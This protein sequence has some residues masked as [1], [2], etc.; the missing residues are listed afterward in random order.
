LRRQLLPPI[1]AQRDREHL[2]HRCQ[3]H[4]LDSVWQV[5]V[6][7]DDGSS[8]AL[9]IPAAVRELVARR[10]QSGFA[11]TVPVVSGV[12]ATLFDESSTAQP[13]SDA[14]ARYWRCDLQVHTPRDQRWPGDDPRGQDER[15]A[16]ARTYLAAAQTRGVEVV[17][18]TEHHD[19]S[20][21]DELR[22]AA[23][24]L[25][26]HVLPG[27]ELETSEG[28]HV[29]C[30]F[31]PARPVLEL[32]D[33][34]ASLGLDRNRRA[35]SKATEIRSDRPLADVL[36]LVQDRYEGICIAAHVTSRKGILD[37][38]PGGARADAWKQPDL[39]AAQIPCALAEVGNAGVRSMLANE[40]P[41][42]RRERRLAY[43]L[44]SDSRS[45]DEIGSAS[46]WIKMHHP[47]VAGLRQ[48]FLDPDSRIAF[49]DPMAA[50]VDAQLLEVAWEG[51]YLGDERVAFNTELTCLIGGKGTG[52]STVIESIRWAFGLEPR[53]DSDI[54][55][56]VQSL[57]KSVLPGGTK[58]TVRFRTPRPTPKTF[59]VERTEPHGPI[60]RDSAGT[61]LPELEP[62]DLLHPRVY[63]QKEIFDVAQ[64]MPARLALVD[65]YAAEELRG[66]NERE[67]DL[68][69]GL[70]RNAQAVLQAQDEVD[71]AQA[72]LAELPALQ[73]WR[74]RF[75]Q[76]GF[77]ERLR[78]RRMLDREALLLR[79]AAEVL[80]ERQRS[81]GDLADQ[82]PQAPDLS[83]GRD[84]G[85]LPNQDLISRAASAVTAAVGEMDR[86]L[87]EAGAAV[88]A[89]RE[90]LGETQ[91]TWE[92]R[93]AA[94]QADFDRALREL[95][96]SAPDAD[97]EQYLDV[98]RRIEQLEPLRSA[99]P[100][101]EARVD[102][103]R[104]ERRGLLIDLQEARAD[105]H[106]RRVTAA[107][108]LTD[109]TGDSV[110]I[111]LAYQEDRAAALEL[112]QSRKA[113]VRADILTR[114]VERDDFTPT[115]F[116]ERVRN[117][118]VASHYQLPEGSAAKLVGAL[119]ER[120]LLD[121]EVVELCDGISI[122]LDVGPPGRPEYRELDRL[123]P[124]QKSTA[125]LLLILRSSD[126]PLIVDQPE[127][128][129]DNRFIYDDVVQRLREAKLAR[130]IIVATH[131][132]NI[133]ILGDAEQILVLD[134]RGDGRPR[135]Y[136]RSQGTVD[137]D[138]VR[139]A[140]EHI[141]EGGE[142]AFRRRREKY[143]W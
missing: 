20:W 127:D 139:I 44:T 52:K 5:A 30:L 17:G 56:A 57:R 51:G 2:A 81:L 121:F 22:Y 1:G 102:A 123:S 24:G 113:G 141:L 66:P 95:Q 37:L 53:P 6:D 80:R 45:P 103:L 100:Q 28:I 87:H 94:R 78:E 11:G 13:T 40:D 85:E 97:P 129:L 124:G 91:A 69:V 47:S 138:D 46:T 4:F 9:P 10:E 39:L 82:I 111:S 131:N 59:T 74:E 142:E 61:P 107:G 42:R 118:D 143:G 15:R 32:E 101:L 122:A 75:R 35:T 7:T 110:R 132:A 60:V 93:R 36:R 104:R 77:E 31:D 140:A 130:Q 58:V 119:D 16:L 114:L 49:A 88:E 43:V 67:R 38:P 14:G 115:D 63:G 134:A 128:D 18:V 12:S 126:D 137:D 25:G 116:A 76:A 117:G 84:A 19:V 62:S 99:V 34:L 21:I 135:G 89:G 54:A 83:G 73:Q 90:E 96:A 3:W 50:R 48:A 112:L 120:F 29:L 64:N 108:R 26:M 65:R 92:G 106:R 70:R 133:P 109:A 136:V 8:C 55:T 125:I 86:A 98:E 105:R 33:V 23:R 41:A 68:L 71:D 27:F 72:R 79:A